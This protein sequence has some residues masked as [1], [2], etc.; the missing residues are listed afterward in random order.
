MRIP[1]GR[2]QRIH[3]QLL[4]NTV[5]N[6]RPPERVP[7]TR[8]RMENLHFLRIR[9]GRIETGRQNII[10]NRIDRYIIVNQLFSDR[11]TSYNALRRPHYE[12]LRPVLA[13]RPPR[14]R[15]L[16]GGRNYYQK[17]L[18]KTENQ[19]KIPLTHTG[20]HNRA[21]EQILDRLH[22]Q[23]GH[24]LGD[25][26]RIWVIPEDFRRLRL[27]LLRRELVDEFNRCIAA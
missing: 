6:K 3:M 18:L 24:M 20:P 1:N 21:G 26:V 13:Y 12:A 14:L 23:F 9:R 17:S 25:C 22:L 27:Q 16:P 4:I 8:R 15:F 10:N 7:C 2:F 19:L 11:Q 5:L